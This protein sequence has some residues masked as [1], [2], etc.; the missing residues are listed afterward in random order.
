MSIM[1]AVRI[2]EAMVMVLFAVSP[3]LAA[4]KVFLLGGQSNMDGWALTSALPAPYNATQPDVKF[5]SNGGWVSL[6]GGFGTSSAYFGPEV[7]FGYRIHAMLPQDTVYLIKY[8]AG[9]TTLADPACEWTP[10]GSGTVY[11]TFKTTANDAIQSL[12]NA[13]L[14]PRIAGMLWMQG[15]SDTYGYAAEYQANLTNLINH[16]R[17][18]FATPNMPFVIGRIMSYAQYPFGTPTNNA[19]L[20]TAQVTVGTQMPYV[21]WVNTDGLSVYPY[22]VVN[23]GHYD[24][25]GQ[26]GLGNLFAD[27][28]IQIPEPSGITI[29]ITGA[30]L[31]AFYAW[32]K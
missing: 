13:V 32:R 7:S 20:R 25:Q 1:K 5:W 26:I 12:T 27:A 16:V 11:N 17:S 6:Q 10:N 2:V 15:E 24:A 28:I 21:S 29:L 9:G 8:A 22:G 3:S 31:L 4:T 18:D 19:V 30:F 23:P 14:S